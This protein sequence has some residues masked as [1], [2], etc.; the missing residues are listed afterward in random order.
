MKHNGEYHF[1]ND[2]IIDIVKKQGYSE[3]NISIILNIFKDRDLK[4]FFK[5]HNLKFRRKDPNYIFEFISK[6]TV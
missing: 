5:S 4:D 6:S 2:E 1:L 3:I